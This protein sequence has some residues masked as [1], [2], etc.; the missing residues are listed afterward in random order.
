[1]L[2]DHWIAI[3]SICLLVFGVGC[4][5]G[6]TEEPTE[7]DDA[8]PPLF[9]RL[10]SKQTG[11]DFANEL[12]EQPTPHRTELLYEY[13]TNGGGVAVGDLTGNGRPDVYFTANMGYNELYLNEGEM[14]FREITREA[15]VTGRKNTWNTGVTMIDVNADGRLDI[16]VA[17][18]GFGEHD[19]EAEHLLF[20]NQGNG[21]F[22]ETVI[23]R[24]VPTHEA[25]AV[26][27]DG[28]GRIDIVGK[29]YEPNNHVDVWYN[30]V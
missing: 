4:S 12:S 15:G 29:S 26:D 28:D 2:Q 17:E 5:S 24:G 19:A 25:K 7:A 8:R 3:A 23:E 11:I 18:M 10:G 14:D 6:G 16:Y 27:I 20:R 9:E 1:M 13:F 21:R 22:E 30:R